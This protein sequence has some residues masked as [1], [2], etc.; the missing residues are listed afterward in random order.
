MSRVPHHLQWPLLTI[1]V[2]TLWFVATLSW[3]ARPTV[4]SIPTGLDKDQKPTTQDVKCHSPLSN[5]SSVRG[6]L[7]ELERPLAYE[8]RACADLITGAWNLLLL[9]TVIYGGI[10]VVTVLWV[11]A[12]LSRRVVSPAP[13]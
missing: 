5:D 13:V 7:P 6:G 8:R 10:V 12:R 1:F 9:N 4:D 2:A 3:A 11:L